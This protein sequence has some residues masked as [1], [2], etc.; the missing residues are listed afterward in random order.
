[1]GRERGGARGRKRGGGGGDHKEEE[2]GARSEGGRKRS[3]A[4][5]SSH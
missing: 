3:F 1:M 4:F 2:T 5:P